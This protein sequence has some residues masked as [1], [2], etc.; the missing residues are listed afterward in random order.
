MNIKI[1]IG[2]NLLKAIEAMSNTAYY[3]QNG[4]LG[5]FYKKA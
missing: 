2:T 4:G 3:C 1:E 5:V